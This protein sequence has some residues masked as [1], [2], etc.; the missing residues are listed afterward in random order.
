MEV[1]NFGKLNDVKEGYQVKIWNR[2][3]TLEILIDYDDDDDY[4][5]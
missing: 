3:A 5:E 4:V 2:F 1:Y